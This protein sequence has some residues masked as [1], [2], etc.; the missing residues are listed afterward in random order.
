MRT[1]VATLDVVLDL[2]LLGQ[3]CLSGILE[4]VFLSRAVGSTATGRDTCR[5]RR[6]VSRLALVS[7]TLPAVYWLMMSML[8][9]LFEALLLRRG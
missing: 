8:C 6:R 7:V 9:R 2:G 3:H 1:D 5:R 4:M